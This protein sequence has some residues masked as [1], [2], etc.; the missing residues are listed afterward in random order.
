MRR[1]DRLLERLN[2]TRQ[3]VGRADALRHLEA[4][5]TL[6]KCSRFSPIRHDLRGEIP[7]RIGNRGEDEGGDAKSAFRAWI[8]AV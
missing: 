1:G 7:K 5:R 2:Y 8:S 6:R 4:W 3:V